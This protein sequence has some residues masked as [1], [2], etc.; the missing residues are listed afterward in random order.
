[1]NELTISKCKK[2]IKKL[3]ANNLYE[4][5]RELIDRDAYPDY[6]RMIKKPVALSTIKKR[7]VKRKYSKISEIED[8]INLIYLNAK[9]F[10]GANHFITH[11]A[12]QLKKDFEKYMKNSFLSA[13]SLISE[14]CSLFEQLDEYLMNP[15]KSISNETIMNLINTKFVVKDKEPVN[16]N[17]TLMSLKEDLSRL[18]SKDDHLQLL[19]IIKEHEHEHEKDLNEMIINLHELQ[20]Q[21]IHA[22]SDYVVQSQH[23]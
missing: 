20:E 22:L 2:I 11:L 17:E 10:N 8:D 1:M 5:F 15:P 9:Q 6:Y 18:N 7:I 23:K 16:D 12:G 3:E 4:D 14:Y 19:Y 13:E 21:T